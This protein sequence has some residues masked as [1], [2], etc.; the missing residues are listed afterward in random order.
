MEEILHVVKNITVFILL[1]SIISN[2]FSRSKYARYF[3]FVEGLIIVL[4]VMVPLFSWFTGDAF[5]DDVLEK[6]LFEAE[7]S[8]DED[9]LRMLGE[10]R[11]EL[12]ER[13]WKGEGGDSDEE[14]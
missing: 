4:L 7:Q 13:E 8:F 14:R 2:L 12:L 10:K 1:F 3:R 5:L 6:N 9:E 11:E